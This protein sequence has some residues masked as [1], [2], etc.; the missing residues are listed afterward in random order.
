MSELTEFDHYLSD[1]GPAAMVLKQHLMPAEGVDGVL[2]PA[3]YASGEGFVG[4]YNIDVDAVGRN[5]AL[6][7]SVGSQANRL[8]PIFLGEKYRHLVPQVAVKAGT[9]TVSILEAGHRAADCADPQLLDPV[10][11]PGGIPR[12]PPR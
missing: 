11:N 3:T 6:I 10:E 8:E 12:G 9:K 2:F 5:V 4:G 1:D 7:D